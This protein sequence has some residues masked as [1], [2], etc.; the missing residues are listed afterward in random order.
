MPAPVWP[1]SSNMGERISTRLSDLSR[2]D[3][4]SVNGNAARAELA[5]KRAAD[6]S[7]VIGGSARPAARRCVR[8]RPG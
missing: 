4:G 6:L 2:R 7:P 3:V 5:D 1:E 8:S